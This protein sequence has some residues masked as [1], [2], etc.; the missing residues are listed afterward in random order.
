MS[1]E[2]IENIDEKYPEE[3]FNR[4]SVLKSRIAEILLKVKGIII[5]YE[6]QISVLETKGITLKN[7]V[8]DLEARLEILEGG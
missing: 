3:F 4:E 1:F 7:R 5:T 8:D 6:N 2:L